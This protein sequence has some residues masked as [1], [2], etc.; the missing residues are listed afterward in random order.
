MM[1]KRQTHFNRVS[2]RFARFDDERK[3]NRT[4]PHNWQLSDTRR[5]MPP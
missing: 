1:S 4:K 2:E 3:S 5:D